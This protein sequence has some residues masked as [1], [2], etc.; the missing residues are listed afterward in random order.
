MST[1]LWSLCVSLA[2]PGGQLKDGWT[3][4]LVDEWTDRSVVKGGYLTRAGQPGFE[5]LLKINLCLDDG[6]DQLSVKM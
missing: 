2:A 6:F 4:R 3:D 1:D 5:Q